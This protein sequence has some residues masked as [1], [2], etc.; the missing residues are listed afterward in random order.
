[1]D[2]RC[3]ARVCAKMTLQNAMRAG[4]GTRQKLEFAT[5]H[6]IY[7]HVHA[8]SKL[9]GRQN[10]N[11]M[12]LGRG[13]QKSSVRR[14]TLAGIRTQQT[15]AQAASVG[16]HVLD[17][18]STSLRRGILSLFVGVLVHDYGSHASADE[19]QPGSGTTSVTL[20]KVWCR[21]GRKA[22]SGAILMGKPC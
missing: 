16:M 22:V 7:K 6:S 8:L 18:C 2:H 13:F 12:Q 3:W 20:L 15:A 5:R 21:V 14:S 17:S 10:R 11:K 9:R 19:C 4:N 1:M